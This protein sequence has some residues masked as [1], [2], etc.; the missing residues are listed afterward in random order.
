MIPVLDQ[1]TDLLPVALATMLNTAKSIL[2]QGIGGKGV[3]VAK[4]VSSSPIVAFNKMDTVLRDSRF[5]WRHITFVQSD[6]WT[7]SL[8]LLSGSL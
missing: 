5:Y 2:S 6:E 4:L 7:P 1:S 8:P 3:N